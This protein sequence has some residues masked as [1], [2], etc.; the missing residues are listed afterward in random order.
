[1]P[2]TTLTFY[3]V[4]TT[5]NMAT[6]NLATT[7]PIQCTATAKT[8]TNMTMMT[9]QALMNTCPTGSFALFG[10]VSVSCSAT[11]QMNGWSG[12]CSSY[13]DI[14][15]SDYIIN[16]VGGGDIR[17]CAESSNT[18]SSC[19]N[20]PWVC[21][22]LPNRGSGY[23]NQTGSINYNCYTPI[24]NGTLY[25]T[26]PSPSITPIFYNF[27]LSNG[28]IYSPS[29]NATTIPTYAAFTVA[30]TLSNYTTPSQATAA[31][32]C[33]LT[34]NIK[35]ADGSGNMYAA[36]QNN[37]IAILNQVCASSGNNIGITPCDQYCG[38]ASGSIKSGITNQNSN[39][40][41]GL[42]AYCSMPNNFASASCIAYYNAAKTAGRTDYTNCLLTNCADPSYYVPPP[43]TD[44]TTVY[45]LS[46][47]MPP[48]CPCFL[49][50]V[51]SASGDSNA[52]YNNFYANLAITVPGISQEG[53]CPQC[54]YP[55][56]ASQLQSTVLVPNMAPCP[57]S[58]I[59]TCLNQLTLTGSSVSTINMSNT[60]KSEM[61]VASSPITTDAPSALSEPV[62]ANATG[63]AANANLQNPAPIPSS[64]Y[65]FSF[66]Y[67]YLIPIIIVIVG[68]MMLF[69]LY[70]S[71][72][73]TGAQVVGALQKK[74]ESSS[75]STA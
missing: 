27:F 2:S 23:Y 28:T 42:N 57:S 56:C 69:K 12:C 30:Y 60:C 5:T 7:S 65:S 3:F 15:N 10:D 11:E 14:R 25:P 55:Q 13:C 51:K 50:N 75:S 62:A 67:Y 41:T 32:N 20:Y 34:T 61:G 46:P 44:N 22:N 73:S 54:T 1:M 64:G 35:S 31:I 40:W 74:S 17:T 36:N 63:V 39:C 9:N 68:G 26:S 45:Q 21:P 71:S 8:S 47:S 70:S 53:L 48:I 72:Q 37:I 58:Q 18:K 49:S 43:T 6:S 16:C 29:S 59:T 66:S 38:I 4:V 33:F 52:I 19:A 24:N